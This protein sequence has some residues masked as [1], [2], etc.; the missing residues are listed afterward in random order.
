MSRWSWVPSPTKGPEP[1]GGFRFRWVQ[2]RACPKICFARPSSWSC[3]TPGVEEGEISLA[4]LDDQAIRRLNRDYLGI[5]RPTDVLAFAL[6]E[7]GERFSAM[8]TSAT[9]R[10]SV[11]PWTWP[12]Q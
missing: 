11:R 12:F 2:R 4:L 5:D 8:F 7:E 10:P 6:H 1:L 3:V 9:S